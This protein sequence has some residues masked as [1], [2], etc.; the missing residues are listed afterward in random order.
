MNKVVLLRHGELN[1]NRDDATIKAAMQ[2][3]ANQEAKSG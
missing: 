3:V 2:A 1:W